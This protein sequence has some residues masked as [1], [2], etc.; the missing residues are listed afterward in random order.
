[1]K[2][3]KKLVP[4]AVALFSTACFY[5]CTDACDYLDTNTNNP[6]W[7]ENYNDSTKIAHPASLAST[8]WV[9]TAG[10]KTDVYG[11]DIQGYVESVAFTDADSCVVKMS[12]PSYVQSTYSY[13]DESNTQ[14]TPKYEYTYSDVT[15]KFEILKM[16][17]DEK[18]K[19]SKS[20]IFTGIAVDGTK[21]VI[22][23]SHFGDTPVQ[24]YLTKQ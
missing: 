3:F 4:A 12:A 19:V 22:T 15:G 18:G 10:L 14:K 11:N 8:T 21:S 2:L 17:K 6:S 16:V 13:T 23:I 1:M 5:A 9:R 20:A 24:S 7:V